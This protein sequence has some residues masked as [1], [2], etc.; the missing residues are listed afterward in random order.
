MFIEGYSRV[1]LPLTNLLKK[2]Q[3]FL[4]PSGAQAAFDKLKKLFTTAL[5][6]KHFDPDLQ[7]MLH[8]DSSG[9]AISGIISQPHNGTFHPM[10]FWSRVC[11]PNATMTS[12]TARC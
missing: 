6:L 1:V 5:I 2:S 9:A 10:A 7:I 11:R 3:K 12:T 8:A 4:W